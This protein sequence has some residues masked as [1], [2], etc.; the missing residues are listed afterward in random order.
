MIA[1][2]INTHTFTNTFT[3]QDVLSTQQVKRGDI[4]LAD[5]PDNMGSSVQVG[6]RPVLVIQ[7]DMGNRHSPTLIVT[8]LTSRTKNQI[9]T[10]VDVKKEGGLMKCSTVLCEQIQTIGKDKLLKYIGRLSQVTMEKITKALT[11][12]IGHN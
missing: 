6:A 7:N 2:T 10:H 4:F 8:P 12:S 1:T 11:A 3:K 5:L 9:P